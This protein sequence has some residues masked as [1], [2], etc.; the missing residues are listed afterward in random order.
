MINKR[1]R[2]ITALAN[3]TQGSVLTDHEALEEASYDFGRVVA[4][5]P[6][7]V[8]RPLNVADVVTIVRQARTWGWSISA[9]GAGHPQGGQG[10]SRGGV[11]LDTRSLV[12]IEPPNPAEGSVVA[13]AGVLW[14]ELLEVVMAHGLLPPVLTDHPKVTSG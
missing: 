10:V 2:F 11:V 14:S 13:G 8:V 9:R 12:T 7:L 6:Q 4:G 3:A 5:E 1:D